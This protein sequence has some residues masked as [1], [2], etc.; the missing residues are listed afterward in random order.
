MSDVPL[1]QISFNTTGTLR[2]A[3][4]KRSSLFAFFA[5]CPGFFLDIV[6]DAFSDRSYVAMQC[7]EKLHKLFELRFEL[8]QP[9]QASPENLLDLS[10]ENR[11]SDPAQILYMTFKLLTAL[12]D[13]S[14]SSK[15]S[16]PSLSCL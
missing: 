6:I 5:E 10:L 15:I 1:M 4:C 11:I 13:L 7:N 16:R 14:L 9:V 2:N 12:V 3:Y 8:V